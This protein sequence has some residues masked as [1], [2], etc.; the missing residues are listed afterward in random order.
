MG[1]YRT[2]NLVRPTYYGNGHGRETY[3]LS[4]GAGLRVDPDMWGCGRKPGW[5]INVQKSSH[6][7]MYN[8]LRNNGTGYNKKSPACVNYV[9]DGTGRDSYVISNNGGTCYEYRIGHVKYPE[10]YLRQTKKYP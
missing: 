1:I 7:K 9:S 10:E 2:E 8:G 3:I 4:N 5:D 6:S